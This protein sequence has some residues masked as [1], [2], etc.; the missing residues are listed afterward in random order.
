MAGTH[1]FRKEIDLVDDEDDFDPAAKMAASVM[2]EFRRN[3]LL[4]T[5]KERWKRIAVTLEDMVTP[6]E[7]IQVMKEFVLMST[8][9][10]TGHTPI[11]FTGTW[12]NLA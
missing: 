2:K 3:L 12:P 11:Q 5:L 9:K 4:S 10:I 6:H 8:F 1:V 7:M